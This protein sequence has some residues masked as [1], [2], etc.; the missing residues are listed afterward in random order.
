MF[1][2]DN[3]G[4]K[5][6]KVNINIRDVG[7]RFCREHMYEDQDA[8]IVCFNLTHQESLDKML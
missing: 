6:R 2:L 5:N 4:A 1:M 7:H 3:K 8:F